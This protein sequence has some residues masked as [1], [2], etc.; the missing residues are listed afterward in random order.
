[1]RTQIKY[2][3]RSPLEKSLQKL[4]GSVIVI[5]GIIGVGKSVLGK[6]MTKYLTDNHIDA[7][8]FPEYFNKTLL[9]YYLNN[10]KETA[11]MFQCIMAHAR[12]EIYRKALEYSKTGGI[13]IIDRSILG[14]IAFAS[15][16]VNKGYMSSEQYDIYWAI[17]D[18]TSDLYEPDYTIYLDC[19]IETCIRRISSRGIESEIDNYDVEYH[20][21]LQT[22]YNKVYDSHPNLEVKRIDYNTDSKLLNGVLCNGYIVDIL[23]NLFD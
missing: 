9:D 17:I 7:R 23:Q 3:R 12:I 13:S 14:D 10:I 2:G 8:F 1:M 16:L 6:S 19:N 18:E 4:R 22:A 20:N 11:F 15:M 21:D 5:D